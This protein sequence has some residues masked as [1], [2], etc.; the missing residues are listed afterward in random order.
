M[1]AAF[2]DMHR[3]LAVAVHSAADDLGDYEVMV[4]ATVPMRDPAIEMS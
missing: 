1:C 4:A 2:A 3:W